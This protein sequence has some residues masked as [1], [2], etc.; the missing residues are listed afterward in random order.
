MWNGLTVVAFQLTDINPGDGG[1]CLVP[2]KLRPG[3]AVA[4]S[5]ADLLKG[6]LSYVGSHKSNLRAPSNLIEKY[7]DTVTEVNAVKGDV[8][9]F[10]GTSILCCGAPPASALRFGLR[11]CACRDC[12]A[13]DAPVDGGARPPR[14]RLQ[15]LALL[16]V[17]PPPFPFLCADRDSSRACWHDNASAL[18]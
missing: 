6:L 3:A 17:R 12:D 16:L 7:A 13:W 8:M 10:T 18:S 2:G 9:I 1:L 11:R 14:P 15:V 4:D 5:E